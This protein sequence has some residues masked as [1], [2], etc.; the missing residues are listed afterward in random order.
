MKLVT[1]M[2]CRVKKEGEAAQVDGWRQQIRRKTLPCD[3]EAELLAL[4]THYSGRTIKESASAMDK[5]AAKVA[6][7][8]LMDISI[9]RV[10][11]PY[12][13]DSEE[14][15]L[16]GVVLREAKR[17]AATDTERFATTSDAADVHL[18][19]RVRGTYIRAAYKI[20]AGAPR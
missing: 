6:L 16:A 10:P 15:E 3:D 8:C 19:A 2:L 11:H 7:S 12:G 13:A 4:G 1:A 9:S 5:L 14:E 20:L 17:G 18:M